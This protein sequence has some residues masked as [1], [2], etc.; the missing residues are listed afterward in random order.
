VTRAA[1]LYFALAGNLE[2]LT[3]AQFFAGAAWGC[4]LVA[5]FTLAFA[6]GDDGREGTMA[7]VLFSALAV[8][9]LAR[10]A[11]VAAGFPANPAVKTLLQWAPAVCWGA[12]GVGLLYVS[13]LKLPAR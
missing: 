8:A 7:G 2:A 10:M 3:I 9:T 13:V 11:M 4:I 1:G 12:A 6:V 5:A